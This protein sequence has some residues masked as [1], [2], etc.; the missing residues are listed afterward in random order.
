MLIRQS[1]VTK[2]MLGIMKKE[3]IDIYPYN[4][5]TKQVIN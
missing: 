2:E 3:F 5:K 1:V 4:L